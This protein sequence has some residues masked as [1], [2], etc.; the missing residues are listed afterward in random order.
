MTVCWYIK[1]IIKNESPTGIVKS[2]GGYGKPLRNCTFLVDDWGQV[3]SYFRYACLW[4]STHKMCLWGCIKWQRKR[5]WFLTDPTGQLMPVC[6]A[7]TVKKK[8][9]QSLWLGSTR[10]C[11]TGIRAEEC[12]LLLAYKNRDLIWW[13]WR[14]R[15]F[16]IQAKSSW[17]G[18]QITNE[19]TWADV[20]RTPNVMMLVWKLSTFCTGVKSVGDVHVEQRMRYW[21][22]F[23]V[24]RWHIKQ[25]KH[26][27]TV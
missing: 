8:K 26:I 11:D 2:L 20:D 18:E 6:R 3:K 16:F 5:I 22:L 4:A 17:R 23:K 19:A 9:L 7:N 1:S 10:Q 14:L 24:I 27:L 13:Q 12:K 21:G 15:L 25:L